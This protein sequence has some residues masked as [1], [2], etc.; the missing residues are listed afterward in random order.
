MIFCDNKNEK[1]NNILVFVSENW[2][3]RKIHSILTSVTDNNFKLNFFFT[4]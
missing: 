3:I 2:C 4:K 1:K